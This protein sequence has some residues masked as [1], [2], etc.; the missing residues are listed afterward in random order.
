[1][2]QCPGGITVQMVQTNPESYPQGQCSEHLI[3]QAARTSF[4]RFDDEKKPEDDARLIRRLLKDSHTSPFEMPSVTFQIR[5]PKFVTIQLLRHRTFSFNESSQRYH[6]VKDEYFHPSSDPERLVRSPD[7][8]NKQSSVVSEPNPNLM[9][10]VTEAEEMIDRLFKLY[11]EMIDL[12]MA[13]ECARFCLPMATFSTIVV[14]MDLHN[15]MR[16][17]RLRLDKSAQYEIQVVAGAIFHLAK[18]V[19]PITMGAFQEV[20]KYSFDDSGLIMGNEPKIISVKT[21]D[22][23]NS[24]ENSAFAPID[25]DK[26]AGE[27]YSGITPGTSLI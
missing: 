26:I 19:F 12:G 15:M 21:G 9:I 3:A 17:L 18:Q 27:R 16:F 4:D 25:W 6:K 14:Q 7:P 23:M 8:N 10:K 11:G 24:N 20:H 1:M 13:R 2:V 22:L 5:A